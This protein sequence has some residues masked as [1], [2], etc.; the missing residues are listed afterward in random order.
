MGPPLL[1]Q[2]LGK[3]VTNLTASD[4]R[5]SLLSAKQLRQLEKFAPAAPS[6]PA[7]D[8]GPR[9]IPAKGGKQQKAKRSRRR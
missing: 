7:V 9:H 8:E 2:L 3:T 1:S 5:R 6:S 4:L